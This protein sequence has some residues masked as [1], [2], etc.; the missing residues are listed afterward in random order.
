[1]RILDAHGLTLEPQREAHALELFVL[2]SAPE[3][4]AYID[5][6]P[7]DCLEALRQRFRSLESGTSPDGRALWLN[8]IIRLSSG[9]AA[10]YVQATVQKDQT[11]E[12]GYVLG[13]PF[14][15]KGIGT[16]AVEAM[17]TELSDFYE[18]IVAKAQVDSRNHASVRLLTRL[19]FSELGALENGDLRFEKRLEYQR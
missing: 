9:E 7:P 2:L 17:L 10:G 1:M 11:A 14:W 19:G 5:A 13:V 16:L 8:W 6:P 3:V 12:I 4:H 15:C 18:V